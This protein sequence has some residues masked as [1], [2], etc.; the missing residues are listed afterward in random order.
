MNESD[1]I[2]EFKEDIPSHPDQVAGLIREI[3]AQL[4]QH[5]WPERDV[6]GIHMATEEA[7]MN[8]VKHGNGYDDSKSVR[9]DIELRKNQFVAR[10]ADEGSGFDPEQVPDPCA[11][12]NLDKTSGRG[13]SLIKSF[14]D[15]VK[16]NQKGNTIEFVKVRNS[17]TG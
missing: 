8:A 14:V 1:I 11:D 9:V 17:S 4:E 13:V 6:F 5:D 10:I 2:W 7:L 15:E 3:V 12:C 16:Y